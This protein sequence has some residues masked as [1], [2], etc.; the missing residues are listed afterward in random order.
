MPIE[1]TFEVHGLDLLDV[2]DSDSVNRHPNNPRRW[3]VKHAASQRV[4]IS[5][6]NPTW[7]RE[8]SD[9]D[10]DL[11]IDQA[12]RAAI[13][14]L[15]GPLWVHDSLAGAPDQVG[16]QIG[17]GTEVFVDPVQNIQLLGVSGLVNTVIKLYR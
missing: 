17:P 3:I 4:S 5:N 12:V 7:L 16:R 8:L 13:M 9:F 6:A 15:D 14:P 1:K 11:Q 2:W 10:F